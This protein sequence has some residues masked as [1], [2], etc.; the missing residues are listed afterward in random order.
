MKR[1]MEY[2]IISGSVVEIRRSYFSARAGERKTRGTRIAG[3]SSERKI[4]ANEQEQTKRFA[5]VL[6]ANLTPDWTLL[7]L[8]FDNEHL[9]TTYQ[10]LESVAYKF[11][12]KLRAAF[13]KE[14][15]HTP[16]SV[17]VCANWSPKRNAPA[18]L[19]IHLL[20]E[21]C[22]LDL[23]RELWKLG[24]IATE[25][26]DSRGDHTALAVYLMH[27]VQLSK[28]EKGKQLW[29]PSRGNLEK[30]VF[31]EPVPVDDVES[32]ALPA[33]SEQTAF[34]RLDDESGQAVYTYVRCLMH[35]R[36]RIRGRQVIM[37]KA[38]KRGGRKGGD[39]N[40]EN[41]SYLVRGMR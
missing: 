9:P 27:N 34:E 21:K 17:Y 37:P 35:E 11:M 7:S 2:K 15:G 16:K 36:P 13:K 8:K 31:T 18:R 32:I 25:T 41:N 1:L 10:E 6:N 39:A 19:H 4:R 24:G 26:I 38:P 5:R 28:E 33:Q 29:H 23:V 30:P 14:Y 3:N 40:G 20:I 12:A 22:S